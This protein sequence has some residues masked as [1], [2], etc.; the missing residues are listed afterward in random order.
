MKIVVSTITCPSFFSPYSDACCS[1]HDTPVFTT[2]ETSGDRTLHEHIYTRNPNFYFCLAHKHRHR[3]HPDIECIIKE[4]KCCDSAIHVESLTRSFVITATI[5]NVRGKWED[6]K[7]IIYEPKIW[8][9][10]SYNHFM[11]FLRAIM[12]KPH[13]VIERYNSLETASYLVSNI[14][15]LC[16]GKGS[17]SRTAIIGFDTLSIHQ[18]AIISPTLPPHIVLIPPNSYH[19]L[20]RKKYDLSTFAIVKRDPALLQTCMY[21]V[22]LLPDP[23][24]QQMVAT[25]SDQLARGMN[26]DQDGDKNGFYIMMLEQKGYSCLQSYQGIVMRMELSKAFSTPITFDG[27][28]RKLFSENTQLVLHR[29]KEKFQDLPFMQKCKD[30]D[31][32]SLNDAA[33]SYLRDDYPQLQQALMDHNKHHVESC[34]SIMDILEDPNGRLSSII[35][36]GSKGDV[37]QMKEFLDNIEPKYINS[38]RDKRQEALTYYNKCVTSSQTLSINGREQFA[39]LYGAHDMCIVLQE[40]WINKEKVAEISKCSSMVSFIWPY[41]AIQCCI[42]E[43]RAL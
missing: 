33:G 25:I 28:G 37:Y 5:P 8:S 42:D 22:H 13:S 23:D 31:L 34:I 4:I 32:Q 3:S 14:P 10:Q 30:H 27:K 18:T 39:A 16:S 12:F 2:D 9:K 41:I 29:F 36:S 7:F 1:N 40:V 24:P 11:S 43:L 26:Q 21:V 15:K 19:Q 20:T 35:E 17:L 6:C 38:L